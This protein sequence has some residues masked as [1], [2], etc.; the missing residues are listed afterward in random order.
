MGAGQGVCCHH[1]V[2]LIQHHQVFLQR[3]TGT[4]LSPACTAWHRGSSCGASSPAC[5]HA[6][7]PWHSLC[8]IW[9]QQ[10]QHPGTPRTRRSPRSATGRSTSA[11]SPNSQTTA[12]GTALPQPPAIS[13]GRGLRGAAGTWCASS[14]A[15]TVTT[16]SLFAMEEYSGWKSREFSR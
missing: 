4:C 15:M 8:S 1:I 11:A 5:L 6:H 16:R 2:Q 9:A 12:E 13:Q 14:W 10:S 7:R 3:G